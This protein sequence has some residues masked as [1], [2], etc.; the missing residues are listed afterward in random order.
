MKRILYRAE[1]L[2]QF[3]SFQNNNNDH[4]IRAVIRLWGQLDQATLRAALFLSLKEIP[5]LG[6]KYNEGSIR[7]TWEQI[8]LDKINTDVV[9]IVETGDV[10]TE[11]DR[12]LA[13][14]IDYHK[15]PQLI[16]RIVRCEDS[17][18]LC[19]IINHM[20]FDG[21]AFKQYLLRLGQLYS[22]LTEKNKMI[23]GKYICPDRS[24]GHIFRQFK[25]GQL[26]DFAFKKRENIYKG[27]IVHFPRDKDGFMRGMFLHVRIEGQE[28]LD[29]VQ[30][31]KS[32]NVSINDVILSAYYLALYKVID[33][34]G[35]VLQIPCMID[36]RRYLPDNNKMLFAN[37]ASMFQT[38]CPEFK[39]LLPTVMKIHLQMSEKKVEFP[40]LSG[41][42]LLNFIRRILPHML[43]KKVVSRAVKYPQISITNIGIIPSELAF[44]NIPIADIYLLTALKLA[45]AFQ[46]SFSTYKEAMTFSV[47]L[48]GTETDRKRVTEFLDIFLKQLPINQTFMH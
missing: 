18:T 4:Q 7:S 17:D 2:D 42:P 29:L 3:F 6:C 32:N 11:M 48:S 45:P 30:F 44:G 19:V 24:L 26:L 38:E 28:F 21:T 33:I 36:L 46:L 12:F 41:L 15:G 10:E 27:D 35:V 23:E 9:S 1:T 31:S 40:G 37:L 22:G 13:T 25:K 8:N 47:A 43:F 5:V 34:K 14:Q 39:S 20:V 16:V